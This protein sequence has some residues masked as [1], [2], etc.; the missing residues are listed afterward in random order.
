MGKGTQRKACVAPKLARRATL[1]QGP[2]TQEHGTRH[3]RSAFLLIQ[4]GN[5]KGKTNLE[6]I[7]F[8]CAVN[9]NGSEDGNILVDLGLLILCNAFRNPDNVADFLLLQFQP[10]IEYSIVHLLFKRALQETSVTS[11]YSGQRGGRRGG[12]GGKRRMDGSAR[13]LVQLHLV[14]KEGILQRLVR[15]AGYVA[16][17]L[18]VWLI[19]R[20]K[21]RE[22]AALL[23]GPR[24]RTA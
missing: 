9:F 7:V 22:A 21:R 6:F 14:L 18:A 17:Q 3:P 23:R 24:K 5:I 4:Q 16:E 15:V 2:S 13:H 20:H 19:D 8:F 1:A 11:D 12:K 10:R